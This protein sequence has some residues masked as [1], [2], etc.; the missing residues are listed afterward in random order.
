MSQGLLKVAQGSALQQ[1]WW[2][3]VL[4]LHMT[5]PGSAGHP[6]SRP[7]CS[8]RRSR[9]SWLMGVSKVPS[10]ETRWKRASTPGSVPRTPRRSYSPG[11]GGCWWGASVVFWGRACGWEMH[12][13]GRLP[14]AHRAGAAGAS[15]AQPFTS[16]HPTTHPAGPPAADQDTAPTSPSCSS[17]AIMEQVYWVQPTREPS[18]TLSGLG[19]APGCVKGVGDGASG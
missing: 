6:D 8:A 12:Q 19:P 2:C 15:Q 13:Q 17:Q 16:P 4:C 11:S 18:S 1:R 9:S 5:P 3:A 10:R 7:T 14:A